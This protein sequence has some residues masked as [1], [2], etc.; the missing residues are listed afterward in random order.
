MLKSAA[1]CDR[2]RRFVGVVSVPINCLDN[3][4]LAAFALEKRLT[5]TRA[6]WSIVAVAH[7][8]LRETKKSALNQVCRARMDLAVQTG[9]IASIDFIE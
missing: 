3:K 8:V 2:D 5:S 7:L 1:R 9:K 6:S 4:V